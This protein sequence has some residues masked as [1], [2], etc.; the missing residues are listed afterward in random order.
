MSLFCFSF[1]SPFSPPRPVCV[2][3]LLFRFVFTS[4]ASYSG[5]PNSLVSSTCL[6]PA[7]LRTRG[8]PRPGVGRGPQSMARRSGPPISTAL[9]ARS[10]LAP[11]CPPCP[12]IEE[13]EERRRRKASDHCCEMLSASSRIG[14]KQRYGSAWCSFL[15]PPCSLNGMLSN[16]RMSGRLSL[17]C[18][19]GLAAWC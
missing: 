11:F 17:G 3:V 12:P 15:S 7:V 18:H 9:S 6:P 10:W 2:C 5:W 8:W 4:L 16:P 14:T 1:L 19:S 13:A